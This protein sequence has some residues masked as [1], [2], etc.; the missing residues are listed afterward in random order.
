MLQ[1]LLL[2][3]CET[4][5]RKGKALNMPQLTAVDLITKG[6]YTPPA[7]TVE[8]RQGTDAPAITADD[9]RNTGSQRKGSH[10]PQLTAV[11]LIN[12]RQTHAPSTYCRKKGKARMPQL[13]LL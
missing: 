8:K 11:D 4:K 9:M 1:R 3:M 2:M 5:D 6:K 7:H 12:E 10:M 13:L